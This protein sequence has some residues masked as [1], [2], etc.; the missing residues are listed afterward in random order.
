[1]N[2]N[3]SNSVNSNS[4]GSSSGGFL[5]KTKDILSNKSVMFT[6]LI[7]LGV[8]II[9]FSV[10]MIYISARYPKKQNTSSMTTEVLLNYIHDCKNNPLEIS[11]KELPGSIGGNE[12][13]ITFWLFINSLDSDYLKDKS[14]PNL[15]IITKGKVEAIG[16]IKGIDTMK[17]QPFNVYLKNK[18]NTLQVDMEK[19]KG[20]SVSLED[21]KGCYSYD[22]GKALPPGI[23]ERKFKVPVLN[24]IDHT[25][26]S[27]INEVGGDKYCS[28]ESR[29]IGS[30]YFGMIRE[31]DPV[32]SS[33]SKK[34][35]CKYLTSLDVMNLSDDLTNNI[36]QKDIS[37]NEERCYDP[38]FTA[39]RD[40]ISTELD[41]LIPLIDAALTDIDG[42]M[43]GAPGES[44]SDIITAKYTEIV[45]KLTAESVDTIITNL[46]DSANAF[47]TTADSTNR[48]SLD[49]ALV[50]AKLKQKELSKP[51]T[52][53]FINPSVNRESLKPCRIDQFPI[54]R[55]NC[56][57]LNVHNNIVDLFMD[58]KL[59]HT[60]LHDANLVLNNDPI[61]I[62]NRGGFDGYVSNVTWS[63]K[64][65]GATEI[66]DIY[67]RGPR[68][69][70]TANDRIKYMFMRK[71]KDMESSLEQQNYV[72]QQSTGRL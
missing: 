44:A 34:K 71:P 37:A 24:V 67:A 54:Q 4:L 11:G 50:T 61:I 32:D 40:T 13:S 41:T 12:Y 1:M 47:F 6:L 10:I 51:D 19:E 18:S 65:L 17:E 52:F 15:D 56:I 68:I 60:C 39:D 28:S 27:K 58:G 20:S 2:N 29:N 16:N 48:K 38:L 53:I 45:D 43:T 66:Y 59:I 33:L 64:S 26:S 46:I 72:N 31:P 57:T 70:L 63:N 3:S 5:K 69:R 8:I 22:S 25:D 62:G 49:D 35:E 55:W 21:D 36:I 42:S 9:I 7:V 23:T 14:Y 30:Q